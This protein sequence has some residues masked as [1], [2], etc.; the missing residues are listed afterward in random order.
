[1][2][3]FLKEFSDSFLILTSCLHA[4]QTV[5]V[6]RF[7]GHQRIYFFDISDR[8]KTEST[9]TFFHP[10]IQDVVEFFSKFLAFPVE[11]RLALVKGVI[12]PTVFSRL[13]PHGTAEAASCV[14]RTFF[15]LD[16][17]IIISVF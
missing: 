1:M 10:V 4:D 12:V 7:M 3:Q 9:D 6:V 14:G 2:V 5:C 17:H 8:I 13:L 16:K 15:G 11:I